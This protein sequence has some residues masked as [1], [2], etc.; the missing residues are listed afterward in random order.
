[1]LNVMFD[2]SPLMMPVGIAAL[3]TTDQNYNV[4]TKHMATMCFVHVR[5][6][7]WHAEL[8]SIYET[9]SDIFLGALSH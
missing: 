5:S 1:M 4:P 2:T 8:G 6:T 3:N 7:R 9:F